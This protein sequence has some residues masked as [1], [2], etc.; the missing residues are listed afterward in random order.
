MWNKFGAQTLFIE[1]GLLL[2]NMKYWPSVDWIG[3]GIRLIETFVI[4][5]GFAAIKVWY[6]LFVCVFSSKN[7][8]Q[9]S[10]LKS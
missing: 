10:Y 7:C 3:F 6:F 2:I 1:V 8:Y 9:E 4:L 5:T